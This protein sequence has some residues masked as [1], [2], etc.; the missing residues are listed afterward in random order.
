MKPDWMAKDLHKDFWRKE[1]IKFWEHIVVYVI[2]CDVIG[3]ARTTI[4]LLSIHI[5]YE[6]HLIIDNGQH[7]ANDLFN[8]SK[9]ISTK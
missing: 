8:G 1:N 5:Y 2:I 6:L 4:I 3:M 9:K 7:I